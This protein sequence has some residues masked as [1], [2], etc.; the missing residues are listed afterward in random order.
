MPPSVAPRTVNR[1]IRH[2]EIALATGAPLE[3]VCAWVGRGFFFVLA[4]HTGEQRAFYSRRISNILRWITR[5]PLHRVHS[6][7][8]FR[9][10]PEQ[11]RRPDCE[12]GLFL[13]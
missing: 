3:T 11:I 12:S 5:A 9:V 6:Y 1:E 4:I 10:S 7:A 8:R 13:C 2:S